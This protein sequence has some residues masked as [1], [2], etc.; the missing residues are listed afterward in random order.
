MN[1]PIF[2]AW[3]IE[4]GAKYQ[5]RYIDYE[6]NQFTIP[7]LLTIDRVKNLIDN[8]IIEIKFIL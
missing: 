7:V 3:L 8:S 6:K 4:N 5:I 2:I 1:N